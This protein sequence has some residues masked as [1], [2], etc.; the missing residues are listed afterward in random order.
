MTEESRDLLARAIIAPGRTNGPCRSRE[1]RPSNSSPRCEEARAIALR[2]RGLPDPPGRVD[3][4]ARPDRRP[5]DRRLRPLDL[6]AAHGRRRRGQG[7]PAAAGVELLGDMAR[8]GRP[9]RTPAPRSRASAGRPSRVWTDA[10]DWTAD[11]GFMERLDEWC[12]TG[13]IGYA[14]GE[15]RG[16]GPAPPR[17]RRSPRASSPR[18]ADSRVLA[19]MLGDTSMGMINGYFGPAA[20]LPDRLQR[21]QGRPGLADRSG[22]ARS[23]DARVD[24]AFRFVQDRGVTFH[25]QRARRRGL[26]ARPRPASSSAATWPSSTCSTSSRPTAWAGSTSSAC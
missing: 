19:L 12:S 18:S 1:R 24:D 10:P 13:R 7:Q 21:A 22:A 6:C 17:P 4:Q 5:D 14:A 26:H 3:R 2:R 8:P 20:A 15:L 11:A 25:W 9:A 16:A 23:S